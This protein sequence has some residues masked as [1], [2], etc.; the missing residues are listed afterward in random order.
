MADKQ[1]PKQLAPFI[2]KKGQSGNPKGRPPGKTL[3][4]FAREYLETLPENE[5]LKYLAG[6]PLDIVWKMAEGNPHNTGD[7]D[8]QG[9]IVVEISKEIAKKNDVSSHG[10]G[11]QN[12]PIYNARAKPI[13]ICEAKC[14]ISE[15]G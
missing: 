3:K 6:L 13:S 14:H 7:M 10:T 2:F 9:K 4:E 5:K 8:I 12:L 11:N 1:V 15:A